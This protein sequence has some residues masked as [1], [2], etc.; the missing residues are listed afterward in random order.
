MGVVCIRITERQVGLLP[1]VPAVLAWILL[2][3]SSERNGTASGA[4][5]CFLVL[6]LVPFRPV[7]VSPILTVSYPIIEVPNFCHG[8]P[9][10]ICSLNS[11]HRRTVVAKILIFVG[12]FLSVLINTSHL[13]FCISLKVDSAVC[14][15]QTA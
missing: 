5:D 4:S 6:G 14:V 9:F 10:V 12:A 15:A 7:N 13:S 3:V 8:C 11:Y 2:F 1:P